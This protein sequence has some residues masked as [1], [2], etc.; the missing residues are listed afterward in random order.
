MKPLT[1]IIGICLIVLIAISCRSV[2]KSS[3]TSIKTIDSTNVSKSSSTNSVTS[4]S[5]SQY[6]NSA[7]NNGSHRVDSSASIELY[8][9]ETSRD[10][11]SDTCC[12]RKAENRGNNTRYSGI[13]ITRTVGG[14]LS[15]DPGSRK[16]KSLRYTT[17]QSTQQISHQQKDSSGSAKVS[18][19]NK[20]EAEKN[21]STAVNA[22]NTEQDFNKKTN[23]INWILW[24]LITLGLL[25]LGIYLIRRKIINYTEEV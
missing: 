16:I 24:I 21:D 1:K 20:A 13:K 4:D 6:S 5:S 2:N 19:T 25:G 22:T 14:D 11:A 12:R 18:T 23:S 3:S 7:T 8:F 9:Y 10:S 17:N 15:I